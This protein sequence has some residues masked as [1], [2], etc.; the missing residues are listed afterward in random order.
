MDKKVYLDRNLQIVF[1]ITLMAVLG[2]SSITPAFPKIVEAL[3]ISPQDVGLLITA[4]TLP[5]VTLVPIMGV[6]A[7][8]LGRKNILVPSLMLFGIAGGSCFLVKDF[9]LLLL[10]RFL[11]GI[12]GASL[13]SLNVTVI[14]DLYAGKERSAAMG[15]N[16]SVLSIGTASYPVIGGAL[17]T[18]GWNYP[19]LLSLAA[20]PIGFL[21]LFGLRNPEPRSRENL[22]EYLTKAWGGVKNP[23]VIGLFTISVI[24]FIVLYGPY[25]TYFPLLAS[26]FGANPALIGFIMSVMSFTTALAS[27]QLGK[28]TNVCPEKGLIMIASILYSLALLIT[29]SISSLYLLLIPA[30]IFGV[31]HGLNIPN[32]Q[33]LLAELAPM[34]HRAALMSINGMVLRLGQ[35][36]G[37]IVMGIT[38]ATVGINSVFYVGAGFAATILIIS[39]ISL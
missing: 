22:K 13:G 14:G 7:D 16:A 9:G 39:M 19:F 21:V 36:L 29:P 30:I 37:P 3:E 8:R 25:L 27:S 26:L 12:G 4:F 28:L 11:Q 18:L 34:E 5:G 23:H 15:Y 24:T 17:A 1:C 35:T 38:Y 10:L 20:I 31:A 6:L 32:I 2:V 33:T